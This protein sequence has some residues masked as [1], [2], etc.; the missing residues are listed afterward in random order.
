MKTR[1]L[2]SVLLSLF[3]VFL[4]PVFAQKQQQCPLF[5]GALRKRVEEHARWLV[6]DSLRQQIIKKSKALGHLIAFEQSHVL[7]SDV[8]SDDF[9]TLEGPYFLA[10]GVP[11]KSAIVR[12]QRM[13]MMA[14]APA[15][16]SDK[17]PNPNLLEILQHTWTLLYR[18]ERGRKIKI[19]S[20]MY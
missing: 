19:A 2:V 6:S 13:W 1:R 14:I 7:E 9:T 18:D 4:I 20:G 10:A 16:A 8:L 15:N 17:M 3:S 5:S 11:I 12:N